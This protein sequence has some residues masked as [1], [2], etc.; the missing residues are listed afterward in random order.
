MSD[1]VFP[2]VTLCDPLGTKI[3]LTEDPGQLDCLNI[4]I[5][6]RAGSDPE[7]VLNRTTAVLLQRALGLWLEHL[8]AAAGLAL[9]DEE[10]DPDE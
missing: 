5:Q 10:D 4:R 7:V 1:Y 3:V 2:S 8:E 6:A 9:D